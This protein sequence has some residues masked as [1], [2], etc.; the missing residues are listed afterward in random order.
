MIALLSLYD[1]FI[2]GI[3]CWQR[4]EAFDYFA[5]AVAIV[6]LA[7]YMCLDACV[8]LVERAKAKGGV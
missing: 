3:L 4:P 6:G 1:S 5:T 8:Y 2:T 7:A